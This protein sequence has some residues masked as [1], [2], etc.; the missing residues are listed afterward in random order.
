M[1]VLFFLYTKTNFKH[2]MDQICLVEH[3]KNYKKRK[4]KDE[5]KDENNFIPSKEQILELKKKHNY[6]K[7]QNL[8]IIKINEG[9]KWEIQIEELYERKH[10]FTLLLLEARTPNHLKLNILKTQNL[11]S[12]IK[13][14]KEIFASPKW[15]RF[16]DAFYRI[17][18]RFISYY[19]RVQTNQKSNSFEEDLYLY[20]N[21]LVS[22]QF[23]LLEN[24]MLYE[25]QLKYACSIDQWYKKIGT[26]L[27]TEMHPRKYSSFEVLELLK[28]LNQLNQWIQDWNNYSVPETPQYQE[29]CS[30]LSSP[31]FS[32][33]KT[34]KCELK[35][36]ISNF[37]YT[38]P[39]YCF[40]K[41]CF[42]FVFPPHS[43]R[44]Q[45]LTF[46]NA[47]KQKWYIEYI[48]TELCESIEE[49]YIEI[50]D[51]TKQIQEML[52][53]LLELQRK[54]NLLAFFIYH[55]QST[56]CSSF[57]LKNR[58]MLTN[59]KEFHSSF[60]SLINLEWR[61]GIPFIVYS[62]F[63]NVEVT[64]RL[65]EYSVLNVKISE[66]LIDNWSLD[67]V[68]KYTDLSNDK[69]VLIENIFKFILFPPLVEIIL[70][71]FC[72][73]FEYKEYY[74]L[75]TVYNILTE[76]GLSFN[77]IYFIFAFYQ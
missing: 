6:F 71:Y 46:Q 2:K 19:R 69:I 10:P 1:V 47:L 32:S 70:S 41:L 75:N 64:S 38:N 29:V 7:F 17:L 26:F 13:N 9:K 30:I 44:K 42:Y 65:I 40:S 36:E 28:S 72:S 20:L 56:R 57:G 45:F 22:K 14:R 68:K 11:F 4:L 5:I 67:R 8:H 12:L 54:T 21:A 62:W 33:I 73:G 31:Y 51:F 24:M 66:Q 23:H 18:S 16:L 49:E 58:I 60:R 3:F 43:F 53:H 39:T 15:K 74:Y 76:I 77:I 63:S 61:G 50:K 55:I 27:Y 34:F 48:A 52:Y 37:L 35:N 25:F 59:P